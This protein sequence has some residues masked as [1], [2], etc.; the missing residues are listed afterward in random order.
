MQVTYDT[1][2][3]QYL[4]LLRGEGDSEGNRQSWCNTPPGFLLDHMEVLGLLVLQLHMA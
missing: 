2:S 3:L 4:V 1:S